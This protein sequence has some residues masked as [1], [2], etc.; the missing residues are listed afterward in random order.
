MKFYLTLFSMLVVIF[1]CA[2]AIVRIVMQADAIQAL[3][4]ITGSMGWLIIF[5]LLM[6]DRINLRRKG[7]EILRQTYSIRP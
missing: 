6:E 5:I 1:L 7:N 3:E 2:T 4:L